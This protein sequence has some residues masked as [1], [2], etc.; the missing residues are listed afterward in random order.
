MK[1]F[2]SCLHK[3]KHPAMFVSSV[4]PKSGFTESSE[5]HHHTKVHD[6]ALTVESFASILEV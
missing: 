2:L 4:F 6:Y 1:P 5:V 3:T